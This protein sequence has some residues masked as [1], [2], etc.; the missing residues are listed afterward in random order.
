[1]RFAGRIEPGSGGGVF[2]G[3]SVLFFPARTALTRAMLSFRVRPATDGT[4]MGGSF[5]AESVAVAA[6][7]VLAVAAGVSA[8]MTA[9][10]D[11]AA[12]SAFSVAVAV[13]ISGCPPGGTTSSE[14]VAPASLLAAQ[15][16]MDAANTSVS[17]A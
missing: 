8:D 15:P 11:V 4:V 3:H 9:G 6:A 14:G 10:V 1:M 17:R 16:E 13:D 12:A 7:T 5:G 2:T